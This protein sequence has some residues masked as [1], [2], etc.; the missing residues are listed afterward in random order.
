MVRGPFFV[1]GQ[2]VEFPVDHNAAKIV[3]FQ[4]TYQSE[5]LKYADCATIE[6]SGLNDG[7]EVPSQNSCS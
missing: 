1:K 5:W 4:S 3:E 6:S 7:M 2:S